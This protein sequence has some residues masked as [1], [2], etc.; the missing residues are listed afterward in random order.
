MLVCTSSHSS[1]VKKQTNKQK[2]QNNIKISGLPPG[3]THTSPPTWA[4]VSALEVPLA[5]LQAVITTFSFS[6]TRSCSSSHPAPL[7]P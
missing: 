4:P 6:T 1:A 3:N 7:S 2:S 5:Q